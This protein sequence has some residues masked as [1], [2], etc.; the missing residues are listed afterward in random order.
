[1][2]YLG[3]KELLNLHKTGFLSS[4]KCP[5]SVVLKSYEWAKAQR[6]QGNCIV[7]GNHSTIEKDVFEI[8]L[9]GSQPL[10]LVLARNMK[11]RWDENITTALNQ[12]RLL[13][14]SPFPENVKRITRET[15]YCRNL[16]IIKMCDCLTVGYVS[17]G[18]QLA[19][20]LEK[21]NFSYL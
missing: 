16:E 20:L 13:I 9:K 3:N 8:L 7:C 2:D 11:S 5:A 17:P 1:M 18:G 21:K 6:Q 19:K 12:N 15:A 10:I 4:R 14:I